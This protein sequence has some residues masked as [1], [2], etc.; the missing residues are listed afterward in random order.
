MT[1]NIAGRPIVVGVDGSASALHAASW[2]ANEA[3]LRRLPLHLVHGVKVPAIAYN[4][5]LGSPAGLIQAL[6][7]DGRRYLTPWYAKPIR[8]WTSTWSCAAMTRFPF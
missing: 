5:R 6:E 3:A 8:S 4:G 2:A 7:A 1:S